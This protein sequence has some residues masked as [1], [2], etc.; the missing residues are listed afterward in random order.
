[1]ERST[2]FSWENPLFLWSFSIATLNML[3]YQRVTIDFPQESAVHH[4]SPLKSAGPL[5]L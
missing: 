3:N 5:E 2:H 1:M 4:D